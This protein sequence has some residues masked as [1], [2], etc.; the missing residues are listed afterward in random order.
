MMF[1][2]FALIITHYNILAVET[3]KAN[4]KGFAYDQLQIDKESKIW[5]HR[6]LMDNR[7][8]IASNYG[9]ILRHWSWKAQ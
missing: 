8:G 1:H 2:C 6:R 4:V 5:M 7:L 3:F 9:S